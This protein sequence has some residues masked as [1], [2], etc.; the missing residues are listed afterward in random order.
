MSCHRQATSPLKKNSYM[1]SKSGPA[2]GTKGTSSPLRATVRQNYRYVVTDRNYTPTYGLTSH[3]ICQDSLVTLLVG[4]K[5]PRP[6]ILDL[7]CLMGNNVKFAFTF[8][9]E[10]LTGY[11]PCVCLHAIISS[12]STERACP[13]HDLDRLLR[14]VS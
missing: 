14:S 6:E 1:V 8:I 9:G 5:E 11:R 4:L 7:D 3:R 2:K 12:G 10:V 13:E